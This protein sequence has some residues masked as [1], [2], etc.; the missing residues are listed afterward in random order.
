MYLHDGLAG[1]SSV[2]HGLYRDGEPL[3][4]LDGC[5]HLDLPR[6]ALDGELPQPVVG[7]VQ[8]GKAKLL[9]GVVVRRVQLI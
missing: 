5:H 8:N 9:V 4:C 1:H 2:V 6:P 3:S 7:H